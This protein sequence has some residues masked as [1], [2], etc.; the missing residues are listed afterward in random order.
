MK[1]TENTKKNFVTFVVKKQSIQ[2]LDYNT[3][4]NCR[5]TYQGALLWKQTII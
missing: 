4:P 1:Y 5:Q 2:H 3:A